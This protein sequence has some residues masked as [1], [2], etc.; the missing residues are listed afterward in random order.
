MAKKFVKVTGLTKVFNA[1]TDNK[2]LDTTKLKSSISNIADD[3]SILYI[4]AISDDEAYGYKANTTYAWSRGILVQGGTVSIIDVSNGLNGPADA[5]SFYNALIEDEYVIASNLAAIN[6]SIIDL[7]TSIDIANTSIKNISTATSKVK[8]TANTNKSYLLGHAQQ[9]TTADTISNVSVYMQN[10]A[11]YSEGKKVSTSDTWLAN[12]STSAGYVASGK[13]KANQVW[14]TD[15]NGNPAWRYD[16]MREVKVNGTSKIAST[17]TT[18]LDLSAGSNVTLS[19]TNNKVVINGTAN[20][21]TTEA[22]HYTPSAKNSYYGTSNASWLSNIITGIALDSKK[23]VTNVSTGTLPDITNYT[24]A[25][26][27]NIL[28]CTRFPS[29][30]NVA[31]ME[32]YSSSWFYGKFVLIQEDG[33]VRTDITDYTKYASTST[34]VQCPANGDI[35]K[36]GTI[37]L[38]WTGERTGICQTIDV[39]NESLLNYYFKYRQR[40]YDGNTIM[41]SNGKEVIIPITIPITFTFYAKSTSSSVIG[42]TPF[43]PLNSDINT[44]EISSE[45]TKVSVTK[46]YNIKDAPISNLRALGFCELLSGDEVQIACM[47]VSFSEFDIDWK[48]NTLDDKNNVVGIGNILRGSK[49]MLLEKDGSSAGWSAGN[50]VK[51]TD[52][53]AENF[54]YDAVTIDAIMPG[55]ESLGSVGSVSMSIPDAVSFGIAQRYDGEHLLLNMAHTEMLDYIS[56]SEPVIPISMSVWCYAEDAPNDAMVQVAL[57]PIA[58]DGKIYSPISYSKLET[59]VWTRFTRTIYLPGSIDFTNVSKIMLGCVLAKVSTVDTYIQFALPMVTFGS[60]PSTWYPSAYDLYN[61]IS[62][63]ESTI[64]NTLSTKLSTKENVSNKVNS[65]SYSTT[66]YP[67]SNAV[68]NALNNKANNSHTHSYIVSGNT[69]VT[70][71]GNN[72]F[73]TDSSCNDIIKVLNPNYNKRGVEIYGANDGRV[74]AEFSETTTKLQSPNN[75]DNAVR[76]NDADVRMTYGSTV[77]GVMLDSNGTRLKKDNNNYV[78]INNYNLKIKH[79]SNIMIS[80]DKADAISISNTETVIKNASLDSMGIRLKTT[81][82]ECKFSGKGLTLD[83]S[84]SKLT[85]NEKIRLIAPEIEISKDGGSSSII[86]YNPSTGCLEIKA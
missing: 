47:S 72:V 79:S 81:A 16:N 83:S 61:D 75:S 17:A 6:T 82:T 5:K 51:I 66:Q 3:Y 53:H 28:R 21:S 29:V 80:N 35:E 4:I 48:P 19:Y 1:S 43:F 33:T 11:L 58:I 20:S 13:G 36:C 59:G 18:A 86:Q 24:T 39:S 56:N 60:H 52:E 9:N 50:F 30:A 10:G 37:T 67:T 62:T 25:G 27:E 76:V 69:K 32:Y 40:T 8:D 41:D 42:F 64:N 68:L 46:D 49:N 54:A 85:A 70:T 55:S 23:H 14:K 78:D 12:S 38:S 71:D 84:N 31:D 65:L 74:S 77:Q 15:A 2:T 34:F 7:S 73:I 63:V 22:G 44:L 26:G 57:N 45:W